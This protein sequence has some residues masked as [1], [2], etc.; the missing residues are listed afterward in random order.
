MYWYSI[1]KIY[2]YDI[3]EIL[4]VDLYVAYVTSFTLLSRL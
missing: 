4:R 1:F 3:H 2:K